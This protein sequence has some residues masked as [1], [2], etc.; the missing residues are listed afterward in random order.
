MSKQPDNF[1][2]P[3]FKGIAKLIVIA[4]LCIC[5]TIFVTTTEFTLVKKRGGFFENM[6]MYKTLS[7]LI[8]K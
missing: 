2:D 7:K 1:L 4:T 3:L 5:F 8:R 6:A